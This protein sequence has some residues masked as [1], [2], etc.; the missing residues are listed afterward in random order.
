MVQ[1]PAA[2]AAVQLSPAVSLTVTLPVGV[3]FP[4]ET[5]PTVNVNVA[6]CPATDGFG[7]CKVMVVFVVAWFTVCE[8]LAEVLEVKLL[9]PG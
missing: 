4:G 7:D 8:T 9:S 1:L 6:A 3:P 2:T 5:A